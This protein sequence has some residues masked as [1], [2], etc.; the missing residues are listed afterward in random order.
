MHIVYKGKAR[1]L[2]VWTNEKNEMIFCSRPEP[3]QDELKSLLAAGKFKEKAV[4]N[5]LE[6]AGL[7]LSF[8]A[9]FE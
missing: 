8:P 7:K 9:A 5:W 1:G 2:V 4:I 3:V 6:D